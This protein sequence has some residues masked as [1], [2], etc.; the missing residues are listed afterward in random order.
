MRTQLKLFLAVAF[1]ALCFLV[2]YTGVAFGAA[3]MT[4]ATSALHDPSVAPLQAAGDASAAFAVGWPLGVLVTTYLVLKLAAAIGGAG[5]IA[6]WLRQGR[7]KVA[8][9][10][11]TAV[12]AAVINSLATG[13]PWTAAIIGGA[14]A[15]ASWWHPAGVASSSDTEPSSP[16][17][18]PPTNRSGLVAFVLIAAFAFVANGCASTPKPI[19]NLGADIVDC[20]KGDA[21][22]V[23][24]LIGDALAALL[25][26][27]TNGSGQV[28]TA[29]LK[30]SGLAN[31]GSIVGC[32]I[33]DALGK[34]TPAA[35]GS[36]APQASPMVAPVDEQR[37]VMAALYPGMHFHTAHGDL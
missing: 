5:R 2:G 3:M 4:P 32:V 18:S 14:L 30:S 17:A 35:A 31:A 22:G 23:I 26:V 34:K 20:T 9:A 24:A 19:A 13:A 10:G 28:D 12:A 6:T 29:A 27:F 8:I 11:G 21:P 16:P 25:T 1:C 36:G 33:A 7:A 37:R 15:G